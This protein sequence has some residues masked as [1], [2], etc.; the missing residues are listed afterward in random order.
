MWLLIAASLLMSIASL[1]GSRRQDAGELKDLEDRI[2]Q[3]EKDLSTLLSER[4]I[5]TVGT[6][7][8]YEG[9][10]MLIVHEEKGGLN[11]RVT[12]VREKGPVKQEGV[13][14]KEPF[15][16]NGAD[17][18]AV[19]ESADIVWIFDGQ[20]VLNRVE[21]KEEGGTRTTDSVVA[22]EIVKLAPKAV[23]DRLP[24]SFLEK[25]KD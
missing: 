19:A 14:P 9:K 5:T 25:S 22:P 8:L 18:F 13:G 10:L 20:A 16:K 6:H 11:Y 2:Q 23:R 15:I 7:R 12:R 1:I 3:L 17:W 21:F 4:V 24:K